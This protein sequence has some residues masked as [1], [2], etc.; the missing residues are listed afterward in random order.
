MASQMLHICGQLSPFT[1]SVEQLCI[2]VGV[3]LY[4][5]KDAEQWLQLLTAFKS[6]QDLQLWCLWWDRAL[7]VLIERVLEE[8]TT[9]EMTQDVLPVL[10]ILRMNTI[11]VHEW[12]THGISAFV[13]ARR[14]TGRPLVV[15]EGPESS[16]VED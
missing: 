11:R 14:R 4:P 13:D 7:A 15:Y 16:Q 10:R 6:V 5:D 8:S 2:N 12:D 1:S 3:H 9:T